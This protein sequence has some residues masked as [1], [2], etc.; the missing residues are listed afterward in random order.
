MTPGVEARGTVRA[1]SA[2]DVLC[3]AWWALCVLLVVVPVWWRTHASLLDNPA[4][5]AEILALARGS[6][7]GWSDVAFCGLPVTLF[8]SPLL[9]GGAALLVRAG[10]PIDVIY[11]LGCVAGL[12]VPSLACFVVARASLPPVPATM[13]ATA[14][15]LRPEAMTGLQSPLGGMW[16]FALALAGFTLLVGRLGRQQEAWRSVRIA[17]LVGLTSS[18][19]V[20]GVALVALAWCAHL[21]TQAHR[22]R[23]SRAR[24]TRDAFATLAG[25]AIGAGSYLPFVLSRA[26]MV[27]PTSAT[28][29]RTLLAALAGSVDDASTSLSALPP[30]ALGLA[31][32]LGLLRLR[33][34]QDEVPMLGAVLAALAL[35]LLFVAPHVDALGVYALRI[36]PVLRV[37]LALAS[38]PFVA[39]A[40]ASVAARARTIAVVAALAL[41]SGTAAAWGLGLGAS[42]LETSDPAYAEIAELWT[43]LRTHRTGAW[44]RVYVQDTFR[45]TGWPEGARASH[46]LARTHDETGVDQVG[47]FYSSFPAP[48][49]EWTRAERDRLF[50]RSVTTAADAAFVVAQLEAV[51]AT[52]LVIVSARVREVLASEG[53]LEER[54]RSERITVYERRGATRGFVAVTDGSAVVRAVERP[55]P[56]RTGI[57][58]SVTG[59]PASFVVRD[60][61][62]PWWAVHGGGRVTRGPHDLIEVRDVPVGAHRL[63]LAYAPPR[64]PWLVS[65][66]GLVAVLVLARISRSRSVRP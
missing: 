54:Y 25:L 43:W 14:L 63:E 60:A 32:C 39:W 62:H 18:L 50:G 61:F 55:S 4:H 36:V 44:G 46:V 57:D 22:W 8:H 31:G 47:A 21:A 33:A 19:H 10:V 12:A 17:C 49:S 66:A 11:P 7:G 56:G 65:I 48:T 51:G 27:A 2:A 34:R 24:L 28:S 26:W 53:A 1:R 20:L 42:A 40:W 9:Y 58:V 23:E 52:H 6:V 35:A 3:L 16:P 45:A 64:W 38:L 41:T 5:V 13:I 59:G 30:L 37:A 15:L 29:L